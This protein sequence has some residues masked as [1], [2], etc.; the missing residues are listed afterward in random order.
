M[1]PSLI[2]LQRLVDD[3][4]CLGII[5]GAIAPI[6]IYYAEGYADHAA[7]VPFGP[8]KYPQSSPAALSWRIGWNDRALKE[9]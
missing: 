4:L 8:C 7:G 1:P 3:A 5:H 6:D 2:D 9:R